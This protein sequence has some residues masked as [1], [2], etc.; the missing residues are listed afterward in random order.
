M[1]IKK[2]GRKWSKTNKTKG[3]KNTSKMRRKKREKGEKWNM[4]FFIILTEYREVYL[5]EGEREER[6]R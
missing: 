2:R 5:E 3:E 4:Q 6:R 1:A